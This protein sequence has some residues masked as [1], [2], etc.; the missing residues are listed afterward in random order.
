MAV[1]GWTDGT[2]DCN[3]HFIEITTQLNTSH[4]LFQNRMGDTVNA[5]KYQWGNIVENVDLE[6]REDGWV[7]LR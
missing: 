1:W 3:G 5:Y 2:C 6:D 7:I 4:I